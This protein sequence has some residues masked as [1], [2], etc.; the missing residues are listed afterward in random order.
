M[1][2]IESRGIKVSMDGK[3]SVD[4]STRMSI[5][6]MCII[7]E[8]PWVIRGSSAGHR[9]S[10]AG[11]L[12]VIRGSCGNSQWMVRALSSLLPCGDRDA[13]EYAA[14]VFAVVPVHTVCTDSVLSVE[15]STDSACED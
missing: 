10:S 1:G 14:C 4:R 2:E 11:H 3:G 8:S 5:G 9:G 13:G 6:V 12:R 15:L 7:R